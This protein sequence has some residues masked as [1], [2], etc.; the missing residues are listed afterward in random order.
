MSSKREFFKAFFTSRKVTGSVVPSSRFL[1][2]K[3]LETVD[4]KSARCIIELGPGTGVFTRE[5]LDQMSN[6]C[7]LFVFELNEIFVNNL[8]E[9]ITDDRVHII[10]D[11][12]EH[13]D[14]HLHKNGFQEV[15]YIIS[16]LPLTTIPLEIREA[17]LSAS[18][19]SLK[20]GG[21]FIQFQYSLH[22]KKNLRKLFK[23][24]DVSYT[25]LNFPPAF[26]YRCIK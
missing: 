16:S 5:I 19:N 8:N 1:T 14:Y 22:Q 3:M 12:A 20:K 10:L 6:E 24:V 17:I 18:Y 15:D 2:K 13:M 21:E 26:I 7:H 4:F 25:P 11:S 23:Q 9:S